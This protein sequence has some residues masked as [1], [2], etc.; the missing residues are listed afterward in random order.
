M[1]GRGGGWEWP[2]LMIFALE[3]GN[4]VR[5]VNFLDI[6]VLYF[7]KYIFLIIYFYLFLLF[8]RKIL[9]KYIYITPVIYRIARHF[10]TKAR[11]F[12]QN[13]QSCAKISNNLYQNKCRTL[14]SITGTQMSGDVNCPAFWRQLLFFLN[15]HILVK[16]SSKKLFDHHKYIR[17]YNRF[18]K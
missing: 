3:K 11:H 6:E 4:I 7:K 1:Q 15:G 17:K 8:L 14:A 2:G 18:Q 12:E 10:R 16:F 5:R 9:K 13:L